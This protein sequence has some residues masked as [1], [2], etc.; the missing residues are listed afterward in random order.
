MRNIGGTN[1]F[2][3]ASLILGIL[4]LY[5]LGSILAIVFG[6]VALVQIKRAGDN[7]T[8]RGMAIAGLVL[9]YL[10]VAIAILTIALVLSLPLFHHGHVLGRGI[11]V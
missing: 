9:G 2:A 4:W 11:V 10:G 7:S 3:I 5:W 1:G 6:H 8:G